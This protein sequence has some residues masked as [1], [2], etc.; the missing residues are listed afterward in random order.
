VSRSDA[1]GADDSRR[2]VLCAPLLYLSQGV[3]S[4]RY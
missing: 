3:Q 4:A 2:R 1:F